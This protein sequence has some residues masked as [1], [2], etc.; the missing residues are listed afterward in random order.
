MWVWKKIIEEYLNGS[1][2]WKIIHDAMFVSAYK[3][4]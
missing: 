4:F 1:K 2:T 3:T